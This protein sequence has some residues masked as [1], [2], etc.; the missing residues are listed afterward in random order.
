M[1]YDIAIVGGGAAGL[2]CAVL[3][4]RQNKN[5]NILVI[6]AGERLGKKLAATGNGQGNITNDNMAIC[7][8]FSSNLPLVEKICC[9]KDSQ[10]LE[11][12]LFHCVITEDGTGRNYPGGRQ[13]S[14]LVDSLL[15]DCKA[16]NIGLQTATKVT[17]LEKK[18]E[19]FI[20]TLADNSAVQAR[21]V[22]FCA[23]G[24]AQKQFKTDGTAYALVQPFGHTITPLYPSLVQLK[25]D[26]LFI[27]TLKGIRADCRV[28]AI[29]QK[30]VLATKCGD[31]I[32]TEYGVSGNAIFAISPYVVDKKD[33]TLLLEFLPYEDVNQDIEAIV[34]GGKADYEVLEADI[35]RKKELGYADSELLSGTLH[36]Q[37]GRAIIKRCGCNDPQKIAY[38]VKNFTL[39]VVG[40]L[41]FDYAQVTR[42]GIPMG[43]VTDE[44]ESKLVKNLFF[45]GE[46]LD[47]D[48]EC[49]GYNLHWAFCS[50][51]HVASAIGKRVR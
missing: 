2:A 33:V 6:D 7:H 50:A 18:G 38:M 44:L 29:W 48:G 34:K 35:R 19:G 46:V 3:L 24:K 25:T 51:A 31:V 45:A 42:G 27:K 13:A 32:F 15:F 28:S 43:E 12:K 20:L 26:T 14:A 23:G 11:R 41:G 37:L 49:G 16:L 9:G 21:F 22:V 30:K 4:A 36:N 10:N 17:K 8:Y 1:K 40:T 39:P 47:V 5:S